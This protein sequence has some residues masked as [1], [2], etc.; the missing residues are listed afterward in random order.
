MESQ[1][2]RSQSRGILRSKRFGLV[3]ADLPDRRNYCLADTTNATEY[4]VEHMA[5]TNPPDLRV[6]RLAVNAK[7]LN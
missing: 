4:L 7:R 3:R 5:F 1:A 2:I 6:T